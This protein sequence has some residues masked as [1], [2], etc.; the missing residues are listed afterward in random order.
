MAVRDR[1]FRE[2]R[3]AIEKK[4][5]KDRERGEAIAN[6]YGHHGLKSK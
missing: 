2:G 5:E 3:C 1:V 6:N 4:E